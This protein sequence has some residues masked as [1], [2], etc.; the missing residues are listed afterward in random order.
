MHVLLTCPKWI[1]RRI[2]LENGLALKID[3]DNLM[4][5]VTVKDENWNKFRQ[6]CKT[7]MCHRREMERAMEAARRRTTKQNAKQ[8]K[9][10]CKTATC[11][12]RATIQHI[13]LAKERTRVETT[14]R[15]R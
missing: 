7:V 12:R 13:E 10:S 5:T 9:R 15:R 2:E 8:W 6:F 1:G 3:V 14:R 4:P 11:R